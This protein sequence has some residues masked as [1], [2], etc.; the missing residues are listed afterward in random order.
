[1]HCYYCG[2][3]GYHSSEC[4]YKYK[5]KTLPVGAGALQLTCE[6]FPGDPPMDTR[7]DL[8]LPTF[9]I[10]WE[11]QDELRNELNELLLKYS[12]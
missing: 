1:M 3:Y 4:I 5:R 12:I 6:I 9:I 2:Q 10:L 11:K 8:F 7:V